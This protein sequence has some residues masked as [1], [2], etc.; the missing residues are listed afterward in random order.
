MTVIPSAGETT[1]STVTTTFS[2][3]CLIIVDDNCSLAN[4]IRSANG[5]AQV[6]ESGDSDGNDDCETGADP[7]DTADPPETGDD[8]I[9]LKKNVTLTAPLPSI[10]EP[11]SA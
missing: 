3:P 2:L 10:D 9:L 7:D 4:A 6:E 5:N 1:L 8:I 11:R